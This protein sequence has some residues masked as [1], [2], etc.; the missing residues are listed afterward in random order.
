[1]Q[2]GEEYGSRRLREEWAGQEVEEPQAG[3]PAQHH[4]LSAFWILALQT[5]NG[6]GLG[7]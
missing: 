7:G 3:A 2:K 1:M 4:I 5:S 6:I